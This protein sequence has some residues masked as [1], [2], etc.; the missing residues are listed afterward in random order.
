MT[1][2]SI[3]LWLYAL[4]GIGMIVG[5]Y[6]PAII[7]IDRL[8]Q[9]C[10][11]QEVRFT[12]YAERNQENVWEYQGNHRKDRNRHLGF[13]HTAK[14]QRIGKGV[15]R[16]L[17]EAAGQIEWSKPES[18]KIITRVNGL[19]RFLTPISIMVGG[20]RNWIVGKMRSIMHLVL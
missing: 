6:K 13:D 16:A 19:R 20:L 11:T 1:A 14:V 7:A 9:Y 5:N 12:A 10:H 18:E 15:H 17:P 4:I 8:V 3:A 2:I